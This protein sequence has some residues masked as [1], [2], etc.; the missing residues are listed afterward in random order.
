MS[1]LN[2]KELRQSAYRHI[3]GFFIVGS[4]I[5]IFGVHLLY[6]Y[7]DFGITAPIVII[8]MGTLGNLL[9]AIFLYLIQVSKQQKDGLQ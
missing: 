4:A 5:T 1:A 7:P 3:M 8:S 6:S 9:G 2:E